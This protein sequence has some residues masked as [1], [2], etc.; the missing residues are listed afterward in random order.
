M[1]YECDLCNFQT[2][3]QQILEG[4]KFVLTYFYQHVH[5]DQIWLMLSADCLYNPGFFMPK[6]R[7]GLKP[8]TVTFLCLNV[9]NYLHV[10]QVFT[11][12]TLWSICFVA[13][14]SVITHSCAK[15]IMFSCLKSRSHTVVVVEI[16]F[17]VPKYVVVWSLLFR[18]TIHFQFCALTVHMCIPHAKFSALW[19]FWFWSGLTGLWQTVKNVLDSRWNLFRETH[20]LCLS[21]SPSL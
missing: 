15:V 21:A 13:G 16:A 19:R 14:R 18:C 7:H 17:K 20:F 10:L 3:W 1:T 8:K 5:H 12:F 2:N 9:F 11:Y 4:K 6:T